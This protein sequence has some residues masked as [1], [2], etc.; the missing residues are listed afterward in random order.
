MDE[1]SR[2]AMRSCTSAATRAR[3]AKREVPFS[4]QYW[5]LVKRSYLKAVR[6]PIAF[7]ALVVMALM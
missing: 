2:E 7:W 3:K 6:I 1:A 4:T 5:L